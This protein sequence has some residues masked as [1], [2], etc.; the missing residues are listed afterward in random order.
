[1]VKSSDSVELS[2]IIISWYRFVFKP[3]FAGDNHR[4]AEGSFAKRLLW[5]LRFWE[6]RI[7]SDFLNLQARFRLMGSTGPC[8]CGRPGNPKL[9]QRPAH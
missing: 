2:F 9:E 4:I 8:A 1:M 7:G 6:S 3:A 5:R